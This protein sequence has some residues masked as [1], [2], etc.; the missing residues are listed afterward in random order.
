M[1][2][3]EI[4]IGVCGSIAAYKAVE[5]VNRLVKKR[6]NVKVIMTRSAAE[7]VGP[8]TF[9]TLSRNPV[10][11]GLFEDSKACRPAHIS[12][13]ASAD[14]ILICPATAGIIG[15]LANGIAD[16][17]LSCT[18]LAAKSKV[19]ICPAMNE[20]MYNNKIVQSNIEK[21]KPLGYRFIGPRWGSL[22]CG[23]EGKGHLA[24]VETIL[25]EVKKIL[26]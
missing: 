5:I 8:L 23:Y 26:K 20:R 1:K 2:K 6:V 16:D 22:A 3:R 21:L 25:K 11:A 17:L 14:L 10:M 9:Q 4:V 18:V 15:K 24:E 12:L 7:F 19:V 13:A